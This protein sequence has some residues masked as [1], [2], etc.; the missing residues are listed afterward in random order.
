[1]FLRPARRC[2]VPHLCELQLFNIETDSLDEG[3]ARYGKAT[4]VSSIT[5]AEH[6]T[7]NTKNQTALGPWVDSASRCRA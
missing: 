5:T 2:L 4:L 7:Q 1:M 3:W 6:Q